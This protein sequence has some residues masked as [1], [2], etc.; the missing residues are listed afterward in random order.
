MLLDVYLVHPTDI[1]FPAWNSMDDMNFYPFKL[2]MNVITA[3]IILIFFFPLRSKQKLNFI[4]YFLLVSLFLFKSITLFLIK[5]HLKDMALV[6]KWNQE[7]FQL[8]YI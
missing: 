4:N 3:I 6:L 8:F 7:A 1:Y 2:V 5:Q